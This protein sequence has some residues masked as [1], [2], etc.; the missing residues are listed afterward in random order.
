MSY[1]TSSDYV[2]DDEGDAAF[3]VKSRG[4][5]QYRVKCLQIILHQE[6]RAGSPKCLLILASFSLYNLRDQLSI[7]LRKNE[8]LAKMPEVCLTYTVLFLYNAS[9]T[10]TDRRS[11]TH[12]PLHP[13]TPPQP[14]HKNLPSLRRR[15]RLWQSRHLR[16]RLLQSNRRPTRYRRSATR[17]ILLRHLRQATTCGNAFRYD[18]VD[19]V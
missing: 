7:I 4:T 17:Q 12:S 16:V 19:E 8:E 14:H 2:R 13:Q 1:R 9:N 10:T 5:R 3:G 15:N 11:R 18:W 6:Q